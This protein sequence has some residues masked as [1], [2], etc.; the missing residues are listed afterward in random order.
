MPTENE[1]RQSRL[2]Q[3]L[4]AALLSPGGEN[5]EA[6]IAA[7]MREIGDT[8]EGILMAFMS[9]QQLRP[10]QQ[11]DGALA[12]TELSRRAKR[13]LWKAVADGKAT[14]IRREGGK[15]ERQYRYM[16]GELPVCYRSEEEGRYLYIIDG[17]LTAFNHDGGGKGKK[18]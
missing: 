16:C 9:L 15:V 1:M 17:A 12:A 6:S 13:D 5:S 2:L 4:Q 11:S 7:A 14:M 8:D 18:K 10:S 3:D